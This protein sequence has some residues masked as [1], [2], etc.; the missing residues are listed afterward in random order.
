MQVP[1]QMY[2]LQIYSLHLGPPLN[3]VERKVS[4][5]EVFIFDAVTSVCYSFRV[6]FCIQY[7]TGDMKKGNFLLLIKQITTSNFKQYK[8]VDLEF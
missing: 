3:L 8:F 6:H 2:V 4:R 7:I 5:A 1:G